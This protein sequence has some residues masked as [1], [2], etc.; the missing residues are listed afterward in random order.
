MKAFLFIDST[1]SEK[2]SLLVPMK[3]NRNHLLLQITAAPRVLPLC[4]LLSLG[5]FLSA[6]KQAQ[7]AN[8]SDLAGVYTLISVNGKTVP[9]SV[10]HEGAA[11]QVRSGSFTINND[12]TCGTK[13][14]FV[15]PSGAEATREVNATYTQDGS[16]LTM[17]WKGAGTTT[18]TVESN[19]FT[20]N[21]EGMVFVYR[22]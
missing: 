4:C 22:K 9:A 2:R 21:N 18:G 19:T 13:T 7:V 8:S 5:L 3:P 17:Q 15:P 11:L 6:C 14:V 10:T 1:G 12:G 16:K 20:M